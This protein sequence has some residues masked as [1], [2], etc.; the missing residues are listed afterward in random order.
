M[1]NLMQSLIPIKGHPDTAYY[2]DDVMGYLA[3][4]RRQVL[5]A[6][7]NGKTLELHNDKEI[8]PKYMLD[9]F[10]DTIS[11]EKESRD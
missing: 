11:G 9:R 8:I 7:L 4:K 10:F 5:E 1:P 6:W 3:P 2:L